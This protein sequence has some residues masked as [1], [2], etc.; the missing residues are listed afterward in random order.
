MEGELGP[1]LV[2]QRVLLE[3]HG[4]RRGEGSISA[5]VDRLMLMLIMRR[6]HRGHRGGAE[7]GARV[8]VRGE[9]W[10]GE[11]ARVDMS[12][13]IWHH[14]GIRQAIFP[15]SMLLRPASPAGRCRWLSRESHRV[16]KDGWVVVLGTEKAW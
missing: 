15:V 10:S 7:G 12:W 13:L 8:V 6:H 4:R 3:F 1:L 5:V 9:R 14:G 11:R 2:C 16:N